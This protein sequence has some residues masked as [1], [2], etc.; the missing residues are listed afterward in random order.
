MLICL[1]ATGCFSD[2]DASCEGVP[3]PYDRPFDLA[4]ASG[5]QAEDGLFVP[6]TL[7]EALA[8]LDRMLP[9]TVTRSMVCGTESEM[10]HYHF[11]LGVYM[12]NNWDLW[13]DGA[14]AEQF[15]ALG[16]RHA[17]DMSGIIL[18]SYWRRLRQRPIDLEGQVTYYKAYW[19]AH[20]SP[21]SF[22]C[23]NTGSSTEPTMS[24]ASQGPP[25]PWVV[26]HVVDCGSGVLWSYERREGW[27]PASKEVLARV[28]QLRDLGGSEGEDAAQAGRRHW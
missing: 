1:S 10:G 21:E 25:E 11:G 26:Y 12:R 17:D 2:S 18:G 15:R 5:S 13:A 20:R 28:D 7:D 14:L 19:E 9:A 16:I 27:R 6:S 4:E 22:I 8:E 23:P 24:F 3:V